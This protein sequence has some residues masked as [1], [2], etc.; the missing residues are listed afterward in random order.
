MPVVSPGADA[1]TAQ[2]EHMHCASMLFNHSPTMFEWKLRMGPPAP[3]VETCIKQELLAKL[4]LLES[5]VSDFQSL[6]I[7]SSHT[8]PCS[9]ALF[10]VHESAPDHDSVS[11]LPLPLALGTSP[12]L[13]PKVCF[14]GLPISCVAVEFVV[15][16]AACVKNPKSRPL[17][18]SLFSYV[19]CEEASQQLQA[20]VAQA[21]SGSQRASRSHALRS[22]HL[23]QHAASHACSSSLKTSCLL[24]SSSGATAH[25]A[26]AWPRK[27]CGCV[28]YSPTSLPWVRQPLFL[29]APLLSFDMLY[30]PPPLMH[31]S[32]SEPVCTTP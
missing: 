21:S 4:P 3:C 2:M 19:K 26:P 8:P 29:G 31:S 28:F 17:Y 15:L 30:V 7:A 27:L 6:P 12:V 14:C 20:E 10:N 24:T 9:R 23:H 16:T 11:P 22:M 32:L 25:T 1:T 13:C 5:I 18:T